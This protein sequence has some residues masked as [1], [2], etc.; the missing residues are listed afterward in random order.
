MSG[1]ITPNNV[2]KWGW[3][4]IRNVNFMIARA[5]NATGDNVKHY[6][7]LARLTRA[8]STTTRC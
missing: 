5:S 8:N 4:D 2:G 1:G 6:I 7:G 3:G